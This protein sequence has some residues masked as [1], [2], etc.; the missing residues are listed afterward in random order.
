M[1][2]FTTDPYEPAQASLEFKVDGRLMWN[3][4]EILLDDDLKNCVKEICSIF[5][6]DK[7]DIELDGAHKGYMQGFTDAQ[8]LHAVA[9]DTEIEGYAD[10]YV[11]GLRGASRGR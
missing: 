11:S 4:R 1:V 6:T 3:N 2:G 5:H 7:L 10:E 8:Q 9:N